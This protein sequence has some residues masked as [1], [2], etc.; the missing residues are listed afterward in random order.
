[1]DPATVHGLPRKA[2]GIKWA[3]LLVAALS[4]IFLFA[5][6]NTIVADVQPKIINDLGEIEKLT[7]ISVRFALSAVEVQL[8]WGK[9]YTQMN[10]KLFFLVGVLLFEVG[11]AVCGATPTM[12][13]LIVGRALCGVGGVGIYIGAMNIISLSTTE[14]ERPGYLGLVGLT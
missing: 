6:D 7:W 12:D 11:S 4:S 1:M 5:L 10:I 9:I 8:L 3:L 2:T 14:A 13:T